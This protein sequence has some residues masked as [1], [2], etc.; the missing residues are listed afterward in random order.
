[1]CGLGL[2][3]SPPLCLGA[4]SAGLPLP[5]AARSPLSSSL[6]RASPPCQIQTLVSPGPCSRALGTEMM[7]SLYS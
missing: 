7:S 2:A 4:D 5:H 3:E 1:M 6:D